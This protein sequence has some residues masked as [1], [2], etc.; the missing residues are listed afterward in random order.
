M[1]QV[2]CGEQSNLQGVRH[3]LTQHLAMTLV[4]M[5]LILILL[6]WPYPSTPLTTMVPWALWLALAGGGTW[7]VV[8]RWP[9]LAR[10]LLLWG[11]TAGI[12]GGMW[13]F[14]AP[15]VP[16][17]GL[18]L[19]F[20]G[21]M[22]VPGGAMIAPSA[23]ALLATWL[24]VRG[25]RPYP[26]P[27]LWTGLVL[28]AALS[29]QTMR[30]LYTALEWAW[31]MQQRADQ[32]LGLARDRQ[33]ELSRA[34]KSLDLANSLLRRT[35]HELI[36]ARKQAEE[37][38][39]MKEQFA[40]N[41]SHE[42]RTPL[43]LIL[44]FS[45]IMYLSS[46][47]YGDM[48][49]PPTLRQDVY[50]IYRSSRHLLEMIDDVLDLSRFEIA[51]FTLDKEPTPLS[52]LLWE[53]TEI[54]QGLFR[55]RPV[56]LE[57]Y[58]APDLPTLTIDRTRIRQVLL[59][60]LNNA[61]R[62][63]EQGHVRL[64]ARRGEGEVIISVSDTGPGIPPEEVPHL[65]E[66]FYQVDRSLQRRHNGAGLGLAISKHFVEAHEG[67]IWVES[68]V[69]VGST[70]TF[71]LPIPGEKV[72]PSP[73]R[74]GEPLEMPA[75]KTKPLLLVVDKDPAVATLIRRHIPEYEVVHIPDAAQVT[76]AVKWWH[77]HAV[78]WNVLPDKQILP[79]EGLPA[80][81]PII[82]C[83][84]P[85]Q[86]WVAEGLVVAECLAK[87]ITIEGLWG[88]IRQVDN[89][90]D[91]LIIDDDR[92]FCQMV[93][94]MLRAADKEG[95]IKIRSAYHATAG[96]SAMR[97]RRPDVVLLDLIMPD[98]DGFQVLEEMRADPILSEVPVILLTA[99]SYA[100]DILAQRGGHLT[101]HWPAGASPAETLQCL[102]AVIG[103]LKSHYDK[104]AEAT[105]E[106]QAPQNMPLI[107]AGG[108]GA[109]TMSS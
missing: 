21:A 65:F 1:L 41:I 86:A 58:I 80:S 16:F 7:A 77:P 75:P 12:L 27:E 51:E 79:N 49:W 76:D 55:G 31:T 57:L 106:I 93:R 22:I 74:M 10:H 9:T 13:W 71:T 19:P 94:R 18:I 84:L 92:D 28:G 62:F 53:V 69:G 99:S 95:T 26:L 52:Q 103:T 72:L 105:E 60:L 11:C 8:N 6:T 23:V 61:A 85:S 35:Q 104:Q 98:M 38:R 91:V 20:V 32:L 29:W 68:Q 48:E 43:S 100:E 83:S 109:Y 25:V 2:T 73:I 63:T 34:L 3:Q 45:E 14:P 40:A 108:N 107:N 46:E 36:T 67:R 78:L 50:Q 66:E 97:E 89:I 54:A 15:W 96:L 47:V 82:E 30:T 56:Q 33:A 64:Q 24:T 37:A 44:G 87:P 81:V 101:I 88:A 102:R 17:L 70:F 39:R 59:N 4:G 5:S 90:H 42:L